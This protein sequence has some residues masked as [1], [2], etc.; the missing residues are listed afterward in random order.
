MTENP[1]DF[2][3]ILE[4]LPGHFLILAPSAPFYTI[5]AISE[6]WLRTTGQAREQVVGKSIW[7]IYPQ[8]PEAT[9]AT[10][11]SPLSVS[12]QQALASKQP[13][14]MPVVCYQVPTT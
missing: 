10:E 6:Q 11:P 1:F 3:A 4:V 2:K 13:D 7:E 12:L 14:H 8:N 5:L 9:T